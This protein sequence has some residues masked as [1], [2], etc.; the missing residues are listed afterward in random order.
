MSERTEKKDKILTPNGFR[1][2]S[3]SDHISRNQK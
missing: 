1:N 3:G 2:Y